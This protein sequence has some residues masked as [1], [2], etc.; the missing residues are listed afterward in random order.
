MTNVA[1]VQ[2]F[3]KSC[4]SVLYDPEVLIIPTLWALTKEKN[5]NFKLFGSAEKSDT[6][7]RLPR[8][9]VI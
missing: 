6:R 9:Y 3:S 4:E 5:P 2:L 1:F 8:G 7:G